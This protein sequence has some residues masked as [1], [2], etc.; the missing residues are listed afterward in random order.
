MVNNE[1]MIW[2]HLLLVIVL[3]L[4][5]A[6][7]I[8]DVEAQQLTLEC[9]DRFESELTTAQPDQDYQMLINAGTTINLAAT[10]IGN[11][12]NVD[13]FL[14]DASGSRIAAATVG[15]QGQSEEIIDLIVSSTNPVLIVD[16]RSSS[17]GAYTLTLGC[18]L[19]DGTVIEPGDEAPQITS[20]PNTSPAQPAFSGFGFPGLAAQDF[21]QGVTVPLTLGSPNAGR[22]SDGFVGIFGFSFSGNAGDLMD[23]SFERS[24]GNL[25]LGL[26]VISADSEVVY[27]ASLINAESMSAR[28]TLPSDGEYTIGVF[29]IDL[30]PP[31]SPEATAFQIISTL[32]P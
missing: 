28:F 26:A 16:G 25:N 30:L 15:G 1:R 13:L 22:I 20:N 7:I 23:L 9:G 2:R 3:F 24:S 18:T 17:I 11:T 5:N 8:Y 21:S 27:Q 29:R 12:F 4:L 31:A 6:S 14:N 10:P 19:R 32:N